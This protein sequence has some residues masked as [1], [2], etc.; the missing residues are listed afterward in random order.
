MVWFVHMSLIMRVLLIEDDR[1]TAAALCAKLKLHYV[2]DV[3]YTGKD[4]EYQALLNDYD[5]MIIDFR[6][7]R[8]ARV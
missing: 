4:G 6:L 7:A 1:S 8:Y 5:V 2:V 3:A